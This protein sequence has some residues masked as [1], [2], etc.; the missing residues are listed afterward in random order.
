VKTWIKWKG[1]EKWVNLGLQ[2][3]HKQTPPGAEQDLFLQCYA[4]LEQAVDCST[5][6]EIESKSRSE[7]GLSL[8]AVSHSNVKKRGLNSLHRTLVQQA[9]FDKTYF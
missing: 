9:Q 7:R 2:N 6:N 4:T 1:T 8:Q 5:F 3:K